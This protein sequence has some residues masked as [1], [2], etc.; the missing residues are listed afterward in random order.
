MLLV[1]E[2]APKFV[3][4]VKAKFTKVLKIRGERVSSYVRAINALN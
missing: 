1:D 2:S 3:T 4:H